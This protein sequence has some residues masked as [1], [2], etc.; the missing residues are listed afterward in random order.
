MQR[1][2]LKIA[3][4]GTDYHGWQVQPN[5]ITVQEQLQNS[6]AKI[7]G[8]AP[9]V[10]GCSSTDAS[11]HA[12][13]F[14]C[15]FDLEKK[16]PNDGIVNGLNSVLP[17]DI[18]VLDCKDVDSVFHARYNAKSKTYQYKIDRRAIQDP[19]SSRY[20]YRF[21]G[22]LNLA[23]ISYFCSTLVGEHDFEGFSS[24][25]RSVDETVRTIYSCGIK[26]ENDHIILT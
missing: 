16:I 26:E 7:Y 21:G 12:E 15:H 13:E 6:M 3:F 17:T 4:D 10:T 1:Y 23:D 8:F 9:N 25:N 11:V 22:N 19:F 14:F 24:A 18:R 2:L 20:S 5:G